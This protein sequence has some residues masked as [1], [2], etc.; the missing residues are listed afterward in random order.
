MDDVYRYIDANRERF[1]EELKAFLRIPSIAT[2]ATAVSTCAEKLKG[3]LAEVG[4]DARIIPSSGNPMVYGELPGVEGAPVTLV[5]GHYDVMPPGDA[6]KWESP[7]FEPTLR[8]GRIYARGVGDNKAQHIAHIKAVEALRACG[9][10]N[11]PLKIVLEGEEETG[12]TSLPGFVANNRELLA[13]DVCYAADGPRHESNRPT[14]YLGCR[15]VVGFELKVKTASRDVHS[16]NR[17]NVV[18]NPGW[19]LLQALSTMRDAEGRITIEGFMDDVR[20][21]GAEDHKLLDALPFDGQKMGT[22]LAVEELKGLAPKEYHQRVMYRPTLNISG[23]V[24]GYGGEGV[25]NIVPAEATAKMDIRLVVD[26]APDKIMALVR[27]HL[28]RHGYKD[29]ELIVHDTMK[30]SRT[31]SANNFVGPIVDAVR[32]ASR[33]EP[34]VLPALG[35]SIP[36]YAFVEGLD[37]PC[38]WSAYANWDEHNHAPNENVVIDLFIQSIKLSANVFHSLARI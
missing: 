20:P 12:S 8:D 38:I 24:S 1:V 11:V 16:G 9:K 7:P 15:G 14:I 27:K 32:Q 19:R 23:L 35:G 33:E 2:N 17:G 37:V 4:F 18:P 5:Y 22:E 30:P 6:S 21:L 25:M 34:I 13:A 26:Q 29:V 28:D 10:T 36:Q 31:S 3:A